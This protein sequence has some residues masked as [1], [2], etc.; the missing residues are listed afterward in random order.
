MLANKVC[1]ISGST[2]GIGKGIAKSFLQNGAFV[3]INGRSQNNI[4]EAIQSFHAEGLTNVEGIVADISNNEGTDFL[5]QSVS[6]SKRQIDVV[7]CNLG[8]FG[9]HDFFDI[10][11]DMWMNYFNV[12]VLTTVRL[13]RKYLKEMLSRNGGRIIIISSECGLRPI[14]D[15]LQYTITKAAQINL[16]LAGPTMTEGVVDFIGGIAKTTEKTYDEAL[17]DY[18]IEREPT[19]LIQRFLKVEEVAN[20]A[21][22]LAS[23]LSSG[24]NGAAQRVEGGIIRSI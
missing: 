3:F 7:V 2:A 23:D 19:S 20:V 13:C 14:P 8:I 17:K 5:F 4:D 6:N 18:F 16:L 11:D 21:T 22:F 24:I 12:N 15:M 9:T 10:T 1:L